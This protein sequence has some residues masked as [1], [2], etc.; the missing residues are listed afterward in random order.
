ML[1]LCQLEDSRRVTVQHERDVDSTR[2]M[3]TLCQ[4][5]DSRRVTVQ[6]ERDVDTLSTGRQ[7]EGD[8]SA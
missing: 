7:S 4:L 6:H 1:T 8:S 2:E 5:E 3:L